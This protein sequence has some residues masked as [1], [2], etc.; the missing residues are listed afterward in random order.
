MLT[1][2]EVRSNQ[3]VEIEPTAPPGMENIGPMLLMAV[4]ILVL[5]AALVKSAKG[6]WLHWFENPLTGLALTLGLLVGLIVA[7]VAYWSGGESEVVPL[8]SGL[9]EMMKTI[10]FWAALIVG[11]VAGAKRWG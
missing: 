3:F 11:T 10:V 7:I 9:A 4:L 8:I 1:A 5:A 6:L 2:V